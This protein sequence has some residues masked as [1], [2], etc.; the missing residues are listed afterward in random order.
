MTLEAFQQQGVISDD[1][2]LVS[3][4]EIEAITVSTLRSLPLGRITKKLNV[5]VDDAEWIA[6]HKK[7]GLIDSVISCKDDN[8]I[9]W[10]KDSLMLLSQ[11]INNNNCLAT[12]KIEEFGKTTKRRAMNM[13]LNLNLD[14]MDAFETPAAPAGAVAEATGASVMGNQKLYNYLLRH[15]RLASFVTA[16]VPSIKMSVRKN[17]IKDAQGKYV[18]KKDLTPE[19]RAEIQKNNGDC[20]AK[21]AATE[22]AFVYRQSAPGLKAA[23][24]ALPT[25]IAESNDIIGEAL[26]GTLKFDEGCTETTYVGLAKE[27]FFST[28]RILFGGLIKESE[29]VMGKR[30]AELQVEHTKYQKKDKEGNLTGELGMR[31][32]VLVKGGDRSTAITEGNFIPLKN[33]EVASPQNPTEE[34][35]RGLNMAIE[36]VIKSKEK[37]DS[38]READKDLISWDEASDNHVTS[39]YFVAGGKG[40]DIKVPAFWDKKV[41]VAEILIPVKEKNVTTV[42]GETKVRY[43]AKAHSYEDL[44]EGPLSEA[45]YQAVLAKMGITA[46]DFISLIK[47]VIT[48][49]K[50]TKKKDNLISNEEI[51]EIINTGNKSGTYSLTGALSLDVSAL[52]RRL[53]GLPM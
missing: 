52:G 16:D 40:V 51:F 15:G 28:V 30:A 47:P 17:K 13:D 26:N 27:E 35:V 12:N 7:D 21:Y 11:S 10:I 29:V 8:V 53:A 32:K 36:Q 4:N 23:I 3:K 38:L 25:T 46:E 5:V 34:E 41:N 9:F 14:G 6:V 48:V 50:E 18:E 39:K 37:Y 22:N 43:T 49:K 44:A 42:K 20:P 31:A 45:A 2:I 24:I 19:E 33:Y 1:Y